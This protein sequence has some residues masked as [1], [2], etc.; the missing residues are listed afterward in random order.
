LLYLEKRK[1]QE[2]GANF[3]FRK[4]T[5]VGQFVANIIRLLFKEDNMGGICKTNKREEKC[6]QSFVKKTRRMETT[7]KRQA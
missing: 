6:V 3:M 1:W 4:P 7:K 2:S 5:F